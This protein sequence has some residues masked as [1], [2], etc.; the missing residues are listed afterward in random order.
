M[1]IIMCP[2]CNLPAIRRCRCLRG[3][4]ECENGHA[5]HTCVKHQRTVVGKA[6]HGLKTNACTCIDTKPIEEPTFTST[7]YH[8]SLRA[9]AL[10]AEQ[11]PII[12]AESQRLMGAFGAFMSGSAAPTDL[13]ELYIFSLLRDACNMARASNREK[14]MND[15]AIIGRRLRFAIQA[16][17]E[18]VAKKAW[19]TWHGQPA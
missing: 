5:W 3:D 2:T 14:K 9:L 6:D 18:H 4:C 19:E 12:Q 15:D 17:D 16:L 11:I 10:T 7:E 13:A 8:T 1:E